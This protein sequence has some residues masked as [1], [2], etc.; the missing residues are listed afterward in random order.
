MH[1]VAEKQNSREWFVT[2]TAQVA[3]FPSMFCGG[4]GSGIE[5]RWT[6]TSDWSE[7]GGTRFLLISWAYSQ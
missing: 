6:P 3:V 2:G 4:D 5:S 1:L 7:G